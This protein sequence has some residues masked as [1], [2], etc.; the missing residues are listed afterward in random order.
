MRKSLKIYFT[1]SLINHAVDDQWD[2]YWIFKNREY[3][4]DRKILLFSPSDLFFLLFMSS[5]CSFYNNWT[6]CSFC[7][8]WFWL[9]VVCSRNM[10]ERATLFI[11]ISIQASSSLVFCS[12]FLAL[13]IKKQHG[14]A[15]KFNWIHGQTRLHPNFE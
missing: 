11:Y 5:G 14:N 1:R 12:L 10:F 7:F 15:I 6:Y 13:W 9:L 4:N 8:I 2:K 3:G